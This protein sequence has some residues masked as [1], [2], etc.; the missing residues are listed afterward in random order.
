VPS[1]RDAGFEVAGIAGRD[2][3]KTSRIAGELGVRAFDDWR[4]LIAERDVDLISIVTPPHEHLA[5][6]TA[7]LDAGKHV[8]S[9]KRWR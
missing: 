1:F 7:A 3:A 9:E 2:A 5:M 6:A 8:L 4:A